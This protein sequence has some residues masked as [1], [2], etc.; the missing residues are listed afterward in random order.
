MRRIEPYNKIIVVFPSSV[1]PSRC[2]GNPPSPEGEGLIGCAHSCHCEEQSDVAIS[3]KRNAAHAHA[4]A[5]CPRW[6]T[7]EKSHTVKTRTIVHVMRRDEGVPPYRRLR[8]PSDYTKNRSEVHF[9]S[10]LLT[11][12]RFWFSVRSLSDFADNS[13]LR[14][15]VTL[16]R[17][18]L[19]R[20]CKARWFSHGQRRF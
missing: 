3:W 5:K 1:L 4:P 15:A 16:R 17:D 18:R 12:I 7:V 6:R 20:G 8:R 2:Y 19:L 9:G 14:S 11:F 10:V 13:G